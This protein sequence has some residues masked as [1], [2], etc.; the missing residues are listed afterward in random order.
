ML[1]SRL[2]S[3]P[4]E[5]L[6]FAKRVHELY[7]GETWLT[8][9]WQGSRLFWHSWHEPHKYWPMSYAAVIERLLTIGFKKPMEQAY[10]R[11]R[12]FKPVDVQLFTNYDQFMSDLHRMV[13][14]RRAKLEN[15]I[16]TS[17]EAQKQFDEFVYGPDIKYLMDT[18]WWVQCPAAHM[19]WNS[20]TSQLE[21][22]NWMT[23][24]VVKAHEKLYSEMFG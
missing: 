9:P 5:K 22:L 23:D 17:E 11:L 7:V 19:R 2:L 12:L 13:I 6:H 15:M 18:M 16:M 1:T 8:E 14:E 3:D 4:E 21:Q 10:W 20:K 24:A